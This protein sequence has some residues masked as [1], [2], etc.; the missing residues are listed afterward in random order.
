MLPKAQLF[1]PE[2]G[3]KHITAGVL[4]A[5]QAK[6]QVGFVDAPCDGACFVADF[7][8]HFGISKCGELGSDR[9]CWNERVPCF[10]GLR[11]P[12]AARLFADSFDC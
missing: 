7:V 12:F 1:V 10:D 11:Q 4:P 3:H 5:R 2:L 8:E 9:A 6:N